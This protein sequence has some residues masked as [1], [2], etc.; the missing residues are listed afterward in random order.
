[1]H[2][3]HLH[4]TIDQLRKE[5]LVKATEAIAFLILA[6]FITVYL[7]TILFQFVFASQQLTEEPAVI[8]YIPVASFVIAIA[9]FVYALV[10]NVRRMLQ[11]MKLEKQMAMMDD[12]DHNDHEEMSMSEAK[13]TPKRKVSRK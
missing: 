7:P 12:H 11:I 6:F 2:M 13:R 4:F 3:H 8:R 9:Y 1:M 10:G 5:N